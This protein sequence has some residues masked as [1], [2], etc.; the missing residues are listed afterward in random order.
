MA[1]AKQLMQEYRKMQQASN[2][3]LT[4]YGLEGDDIFKWVVFIRG[5]EG[6]MYHG[7]I[8]R[9]LLRFEDNYPMKGPSVQFTSPILHP[10][11]YRDGKV[12]ISILQS[13]WSPVLTVEHVVL[14]V[15]SLL[16]DPN[17]DSPANR[18]A[19]EQWKSNQKEFS[20]RLA[21]VMAPKDHVPADLVFAEIEKRCPGC[22]C[23]RCGAKCNTSLPVCS[24]PCNCA[25]LDDDAFD[26]GYDDYAYGDDDDGDGDGDA[27]SKGATP[28]KSRTPRMASA[29]VLPLDSTGE[30]LTQLSK[31]AETALAREKST[32]SQPMADS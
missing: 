2:P 29:S 11:I 25:D 21:Q 3:H 24:L 30:L 32:A 4:V 7:G 23:T 20:A 22:S 17:F 5:P 27:S 13:D 9:A 12:C 31:A 28:K 10:N 6:T 19:S 26:D 16:S 15:I 18:E 1:A 14:S 8:F